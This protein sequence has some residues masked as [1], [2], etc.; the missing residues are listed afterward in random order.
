[1]V[2]WLK[3]SAF[4]ASAPREKDGVQTPTMLV[5]HRRICQQAGTDL[6]DANDMYVVTER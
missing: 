3:P 2:G 6:A 1:M 4:H 5:L